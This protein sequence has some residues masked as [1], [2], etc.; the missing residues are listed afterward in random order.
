LT[1]FNLPQHLAHEHLWLQAARIVP[2][3]IATMGLNE[4]ITVINKSN[5]V[6]SSVSYYPAVA[7]L[8]LPWVY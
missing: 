4:T 8:H 6:V 7:S 1:S 3:D 5:K 2:L